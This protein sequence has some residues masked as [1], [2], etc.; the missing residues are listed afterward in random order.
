MLSADVIRRHVDFS[1]G[2]FECFICGPPVMMDAVERALRSLGV[3]IGD[4]HAEKFNLV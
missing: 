4:I 3:P 1:Q 2:R